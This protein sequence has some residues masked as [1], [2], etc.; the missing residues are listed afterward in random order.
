LGACRDYIRRACRQF[1]SECEILTRQ[2]TPGGGV[3][4]VR[5][6]CVVTPSEDVEDF[7][8]GIVK[9]KM[10]ELVKRL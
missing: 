7:A 6:L 2:S 9:R 10:C 8:H 4:I 5:N 1:E 3:S